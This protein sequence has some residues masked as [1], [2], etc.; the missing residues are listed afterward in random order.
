MAIL[1]KYGGLTC[2]RTGS[3]VRLII[4]MY[5]STLGLRVIKKNLARRAE[6]V[7]ELDGTDDHPVALDDALGERHAEDEIAC[8]LWSDVFVMVDNGHTSQYDHY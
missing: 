5:H 2:S 3:H 7:D 4:L 1:V 8:N 6:A